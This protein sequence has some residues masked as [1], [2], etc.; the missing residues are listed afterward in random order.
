MAHAPPLLWTWD[1]EAA[2][3]RPRPAFIAEAK[4]VYVDGGIYRLGEIEHRSDVSHNHQFAWLN[5]AWKNLPEHYAQEF[6]SAEHL[7]KWALIQAGYYNETLI[8][9]GSNAVAISVAKAMRSMDEFSQI[10]VRGD[11]VVRREAKSQ[12]KSEMDK[13]E[14]QASKTA[15]MEIVAP[16]IGVTANE[17]QAN[18]G[19]AA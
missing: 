6:P 10:V 1:A 7:R 17:L 9:V 12:K 11:L 4:R 16:M 15:M 19:R 5:E 13:A 18:A 3:M 14:F 2:V 8:D